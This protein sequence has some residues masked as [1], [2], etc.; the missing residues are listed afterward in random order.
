MRASNR[1]HTRLLTANLRHLP[2]LYL[3]RAH[4][5]RTQ[6][7][8]SGARADLV[9]ALLADHLELDRARDGAA[10]PEAVPEVARHWTQAD[11]LIRETGYGRR[12]AELQL[13][14]ARLKHHQSRPFGA[15]AALTRVESHIR[16]LGQWGLWPQLHVVATELGL[17]APPIDP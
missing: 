16:V 4:Y 9:A 11:R 15:G 6:S 12:E 5:R 3:I 14:E 10:V 7:D 8:P 2:N 13:L 1:T 17:P